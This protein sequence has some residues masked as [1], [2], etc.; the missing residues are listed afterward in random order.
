MAKLLSMHPQTT[1]RFAAEGILQARKANNRGELL[2]K[3][4]TGPLLKVQPGKRFKDRPKC[5]SNT[6]N[7][8]QY[9]V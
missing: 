2:F 6:A 4:I 9:E 7:E 8:V 5:A 1:R 3:P